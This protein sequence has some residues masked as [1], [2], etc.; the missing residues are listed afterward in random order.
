MSWENYG[1]INYLEYGGCLVRN[2]F[3]DEELQSIKDPKTIENTF[4]VFY[5][6]K[7]DD[8]YIAA[9]YCVD[10][11]DIGIDE[12]NQIAA[13][14]GTSDEIKFKTRE[15]ILKDYPLE[16]LAVE[17]VETMGM[18]LQAVSYHSMYPSTVNDLILT[19]NELI[20]WMK[21]LGA[22]DIIY[23]TDIKKAIKDNLKKYNA[24]DDDIKETIS[25]ALR[26]LENEDI[27]IEDA[28]D[29]AVTVYEESLYEEI[30]K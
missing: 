26:Q 23:E 21:D 4:D 3:S 28:I 18:Q 27:T 10:T 7:V 17:Y 30:E 6:N 8:K 25:Y 1:D 15:E 2:H 22:L 9:L 13:T 29:R 16:K 24:S 12:I 11:D 20:E 19:E 14:F 5:L